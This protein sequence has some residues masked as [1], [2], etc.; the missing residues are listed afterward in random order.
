MMTHMY[1]TVFMIDVMVIPI[2]M[3]SIREY[4]YALS[5]LMSLHKLVQAKYQ[6]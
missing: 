1:C 5:Y 4:S 3:L 6:R 2:N